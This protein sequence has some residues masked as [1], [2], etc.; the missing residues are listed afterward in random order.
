MPL[1]ARRVAVVGAGISGVCVAA[2]LLKFGVDVVVFERGSVAGG[3]W[4][5]DDRVALDP[6]YPNVDPGLGDYVVRPEGLDPG[7]ETDLAPPGACYYG[8]RNN[9]ETCLMQSS[10]ARWPEGT[11]NFVSQNMMDEYI[12]RVSKDHGVD[13]VTHYGIRVDKAV[14]DE[15]KEEW[16]VRTA[17]IESS[18]GT[19]R[20][21]I[22]HWTFDAL[23]VASGHYNAPK[24]PDFPG[25]KLLKSMY[26][27]RVQHS[28]S[29]RKPDAFAG[30]NIL[31]IGAGVSSWDIARETTRK[32]TTV[33][34]SSRAGQF[35]LPASLLPDRTIRI[36]GVISLEVANNPKLESELTVDDPIPARIMLER[37]SPSD[38]GSEPIVLE[39]VIHHIILCTGYMISYPY[40]PQ[41]HRA[42]SE[43]ATSPCESL[44]EDS[45]TDTSSTE[46]RHEDHLAPVVNEEGTVIS[47]LYMHTFA[48]NNP[49]LA[50]VGSIYHTAT[51]SLF[52]FQAQMV[53]RV[54]AG[55]A[56][57]PPQSVMVDWCEKLA[58]KQGLTRNLRSLRA[59]G[60]EIRFV[61]EIVDWMN[62]EW[63]KLGPD[64]QTAKMV[65]HTPAWIERYQLRKGI[66]KR[67]LTEGTLEDFEAFLAT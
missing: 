35:D 29:Y 25:L 65:G 2:H 62:D 49:S 46:E 28:K 5:L 67:I 42:Q 59:D 14:F 44:S 60:E 3:V 24:V 53:A 55:F 61:N 63:R 31:L 30:K 58:R 39:G 26:P 64:T 43:T 37:G 48:L 10:L 12:Q 17:R 23:V 38:G 8:L 1:P 4:H 66:V 32:G 41:I 40:L 13:A 6:E 7:D 20:R 36:G 52:D 34:Q 19:F 56:Q 27:N 15:V 18:G 51:F 54:L 45:A 16:Q 11:P 22:E 47:P 9:V 33:Y 50:F 57:C 21:S